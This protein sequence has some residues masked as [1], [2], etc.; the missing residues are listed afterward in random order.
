VSDVATTG[1]RTPVLRR[2]KVLVLYLANS[3]LASNVVAWALYDGTGEESAE[4]GDHPDAPY[5]TGLAALRAGWRLFQASPLVPAAPGAEY[6]TSYQKFEFFFEKIVEST[7][8]D[9]ADV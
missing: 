4:S 5:S 3:S 7:G 9:S 1:A 6:S 2:Q 8:G